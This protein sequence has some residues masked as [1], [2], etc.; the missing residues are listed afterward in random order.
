MLTALP[1][2]EMQANIPARA[3]FKRSRRMRLRPPS[4]TSLRPTTDGLARSSSRPPVCA[5]RLVCLRA[6][7][8]RWPA[9]ARPTRGGA[10]LGIP[11]SAQRVQAGMP[12]IRGRLAAWAPG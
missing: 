11:A 6:G 10:G 3:A 5:R 4:P 2:I 7:G 8:A 12:P 1:A 9:R